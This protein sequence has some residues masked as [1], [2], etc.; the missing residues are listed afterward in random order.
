MLVTDDVE[1]AVCLVVD[2]CKSQG[3]AIRGRAQRWLAEGRRPAAESRR[4]RRR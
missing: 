2:A 4:K 3:R 1:E